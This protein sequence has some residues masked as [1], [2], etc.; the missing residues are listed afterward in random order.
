MK[1]TLRPLEPQD[2]DFLYATENDTTIWHDSIT[3][4]P[5]SRHTLATYIATQA[6][7]I[8]ADRQLR[9]IIQTDTCPEPVGIIDLYDFD[10][11]NNHAQ[12]GIVIAPQYR[13]KGIASE[14]FRQIISYSRDI[15]HLH[16]LYAV[17]SETNIHSTAA[18]KKVGFQHTATLPDWFFDGKNHKKAL[19]LQKILQKVC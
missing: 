9:L 6:S 3:S 14:A 15:L 1:V 4:V 19:V 2:L 11:R 18:L 10:P 13:G 12:L 7:D 17:V 5:Y 8:Y 16:Q